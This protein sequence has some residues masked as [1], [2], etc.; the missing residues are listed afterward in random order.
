MLT[1][2]LRPF[3]ERVQQNHVLDAIGDGNGF[4]VR[5]RSKGLEPGI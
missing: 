2:R 3:L 5:T 4:A 1:G